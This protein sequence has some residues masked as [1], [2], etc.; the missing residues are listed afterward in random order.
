MFLRSEALESRRLL[1]VQLL[2]DI[3]PATSSSPTDLTSVNGTLFFAANDVANGE[4]LWKSD[5]AGT[6]LV[7]NILPKSASSTPRDLTDVNGT[8]FF[9]TFHPT[10]GTDLWKSDGSSAGTTLVKDISDKQ[11]PNNRRLLDT[12]VVGE[13]F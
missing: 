9:S 6:S 1:A 7:K 3:N 5:G 11:G 10:R 13:K 4:E 8:L 12:T 2:A